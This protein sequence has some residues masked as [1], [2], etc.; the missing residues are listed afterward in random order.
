MTRVIRI[1]TRGS[2]LAIVQAEIAA[3][4][5]RQRFPAVQLRIELLSTAG[6]RDGAA[7]ISELAEGAFTSDLETA[8]RAGTIDLA[9]HSAKDLPVESRPD[10]P[11]RAVL[12]RADPREAI[13]SPIGGLEDLPSGA[14]VGTSSAAR[15]AQL[16]WARPD[17][18]PVPIR[19]GVDDR[20]RQ[21]AAGRYDALLAAAAGLDRLGHRDGVTR[22]PSRRLVPAP[23]QGV[24]A[25]Q[26]RKSDR[27]LDRMVRAL[28]HWPSWLVARAERSFAAAVAGVDTVVGA[29]AWI[30]GGQL[31]LLGL[32]GPGPEIPDGEP[33]RAVIAGP[34]RD[35]VK[36]G[37]RLARRM[38]AGSRV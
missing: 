30:R 17:L 24:L 11:I 25:L 3:T 38:M 18:L 16:R 20:L 29:L 23:A 19:G 10:L 26:I 15:T 37:H 12:R 32:L 6:D 9:V 31:I 35:A 7:P 36:L 27:E 34:P 28:N 1:G 33:R 4:A 22:V 21:L 14:R 5:I 2:P 13:V 8:L